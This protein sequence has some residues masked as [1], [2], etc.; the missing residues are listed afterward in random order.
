[1][2]ESSSSPHSSFHIYLSFASI[3]LDKTY[4]YDILY[5]DVLY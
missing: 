5:Y 4:L 3:K 1:M 2:N